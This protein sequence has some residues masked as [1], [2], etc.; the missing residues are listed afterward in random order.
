ME[1]TAQ[2]SENPVQSPAVGFGAQGLRLAVPHVMGVLNVTPDSFSDGGLYL[3]RD[4]AV[5]RA[6]HMVEAGAVFIDVGGAST[7]PGAK[8]V[9]VAVQIDRTV[10][11]IERLAEELSAQQRHD[12]AIS[13]DTTSSEVAE[14]ALR[15]GATVVNDVSAGTHDPDIL[16]LSGEWGARIVLMHMLGTPQT[17]QND[18]RY[19]DVIGEVSEYLIERV[20]IAQAAGIPSANIYVDPGIGFGKTLQHNLILIACLDQLRANVQSPVLLGASRKSFIGAA[21]GLDVDNRDEATLATVVW[22][23]QIGA[24]VV[25][26]HDVEMACRALALMNAVEGATVTDSANKQPQPSSGGPNEG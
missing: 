23:A 5:E 15:A 11:V 9:S 8:E 3:E 16:A 20:D 10:P 7:R 19:D 6:L 26:V 14:A 1:A 12:V 2:A 25:R 4:A 21:L 24:S 13:I 18:P 22:A 17:M